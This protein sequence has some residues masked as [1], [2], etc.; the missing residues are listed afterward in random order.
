[1]NTPSI[2]H[3]STALRYPTLLAWRLQQWWRCWVARPE[4]SLSGGSEGAE[5]RDLDLQA[6]SPHQAKDLNL[7]ANGDTRLAHLEAQAQ[8]ERIKTDYLTRPYL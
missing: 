3:Q 8:L 4:D 5:R 7:L 1:M 6:L 2:T